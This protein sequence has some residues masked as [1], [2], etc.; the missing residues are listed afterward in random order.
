MS[1]L[2]LIVKLSSIKHMYRITDREIFKKS[3]AHIQG[4]LR[5]IQFYYSTC[6][7]PTAKLSRNSVLKLSYQMELNHIIY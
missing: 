7:T 3:K 1:S 6:K 2:L 4:L 5:A